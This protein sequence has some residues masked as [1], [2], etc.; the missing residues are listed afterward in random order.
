MNQDNVAVQDISQVNPVEA[1]LVRL[2]EDARR[3]EELYLRRRTQEEYHE[4]DIRVRGGWWRFKKSL[5][6]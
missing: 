3:L 4:G 6:E 2:T 5:P 1:R